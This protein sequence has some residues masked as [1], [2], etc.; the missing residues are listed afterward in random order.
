MGA[1]VSITKQHEA[2]TITS[3]CKKPDKVIFIIFDSIAYKVPIYLLCN[4]DR[5]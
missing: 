5:S 2:G 3:D 4:V 1:S